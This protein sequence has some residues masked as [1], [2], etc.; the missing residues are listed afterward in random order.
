MHAE[1]PDVDPPRSVSSLYGIATGQA[2]AYFRRYGQLPLSPCIYLVGVFQ[3][4]DS[5]RSSSPEALCAGH[6]I[7]VSDT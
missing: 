2:V 3:I 1:W 7:M 5:T 4:L 6:R